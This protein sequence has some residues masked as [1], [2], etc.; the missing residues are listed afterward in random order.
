MSQIA[1]LGAGLAGLAAA[2]RARQLG[3]QVDLYEKNNCVGGHAHSHEVNGFVFDEGPHISFTKNSEIKDLFAQAVNDKFLEQDASVTNY[4]QDY[5]VR[6]PAQ[7]NLYGL[8]V[9]VVERCIVDF[10]KAQYEAGKPIKTY[11]DWCY[12]GLGKTFSEEFTFRYTR[13]YWTTEASNMSTDWVGQRMYPPKLEE[14]VRGALTSHDENYHYLTRFRYPLKGGFAAYVNAVSNGQ[15]VHLNSELVSVDLPRRELEFAN[16]KKANFEVLISS[17]PLPELICRIKDVPAQV[18]TAAQELICTSLVVV[19]VGI[20]R[21]EEFPDAHWMYF[22]DEDIIFSRVNF[23]HRLSPNN[24][25]SGCGSIQ[26]EVYHSKYCP[27]SCDD[28]L[29][30]TIEDMN[31]IGLLSKNDRILVAQEQRIPYANVLFDLN[32]AANLAIVQNYL[33][34]QG[35]ICCGRY[36]EWAYYW[37]DDSILSGWRAAEKA[38]QVRL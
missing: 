18:A 9:D 21:D 30:R 34:E 4:W 23:P 24:V 27:L 33:A 7:C 31:K 19:N 13:K 1:V 20:E 36:G 2:Q 14:V 8:P 15:S 35:I 11:A 28:V 37:T 17:L 25:P 6:H 26:L 5:W 38:I 22:Y 3:F 32:R 16:G 29:N 10:V 12:Q